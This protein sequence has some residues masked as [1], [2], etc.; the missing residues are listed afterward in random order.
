[1]SRSRITLLN[2]Q[3]KIFERLT[4]EEAG[5]LIKFIFS[6][7]IADKKGEVVNAPDRNTEI[8]FGTI[9]DSVKK[10][11]KEL[12]KEE[13]V[14]SFIPT[15]EDVVSFFVSN[16]YKKESAE[17]AFDYYSSGTSSRSKYWKDSNNRPVKN[18]RRKMRT[19]WFIDENKRNDNAPD[20]PNLEYIDIKAAEEIVKGISPVSL[21]EKK[22]GQEKEKYIN[23]IMNLNP[24]YKPLKSG[25]VKIKPL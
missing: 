15:K 6:W 7:S 10:Y 11:R 20:D 8:L 1:M 5:K 17:K 21:S 24:M 19:V 9:E 22:T 12:E 16:G 18:W 14:E 25:W 2:H 3:Y 13:S 4:D 23:K